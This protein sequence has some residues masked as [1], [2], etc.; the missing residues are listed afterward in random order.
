M[1]RYLIT[2]ALLSLTLLIPSTTRAD[3]DALG[4][5]PAEYE[6]V[7][8]LDTRQ[9]ID[10]NMFETIWAEVQNRQM[11]AKL[12]LLETLTGVD[13]LTDV[14]RLTFFS[15][16]NDDDSACALFEGR[17]DEA[18]LLMLVQANDSYKSYTI[19]NQTVHEWFDE[20]EQAMRYAIFPE[21]G[22][23]GIWNSKAAIEKSIDALT[24]PSKSLAK[25][26][27][28]KK[29]PSGAEQLA[30]W[31]ILITRQ[32]TCP[33][34]KLRV[35]SASMT[36]KIDNQTML[37]D[38]IVTPETADIVPQWLDL[39]KG[40]KALLQIQRDN[41]EAAGM[42][43]RLT[44]NETNGG[45]AVSIRGSLDSGTLLDIIRAKAQSRR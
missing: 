4:I 20:K 41:P 31:G 18:R 15:R 21:D 42:A 33:G 32:T 19:G 40:A 8:S 14:D 30:G 24:D 44:V 45:S 43:N 28:A 29:V 1:I 38:M 39:A 2:C 34:A 3:Y 22:V 13:L 5:V 36:M 37:L 25:T 6:V 10:S 12:G 26:P 7:I 23:L 35:S 27:D 16:V 11:K 9:I 17:F